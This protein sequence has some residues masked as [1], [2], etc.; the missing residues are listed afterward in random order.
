MPQRREIGRILN[1]SHFLKSSHSSQT[2]SR[3]HKTENH[4]PTLVTLEPPSAERPTCESAMRH[5]EK[6]RAAFWETKNL[7]LSHPTIIREFRPMPT[8]P[9]TMRH[10]EQA[11]KKEDRKDSQTVSFSQIVSRLPTREIATQPSWVRDAVSVTP[12]RYPPYLLI[13]SFLSASSVPSVVNPP[14]PSWE[15]ACPELHYGS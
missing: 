13:A 4:P 1:L 3:S 7:K 10:F 14:L 9:R 12:Q 6:N 15:R 2:V 11:V 8:T 5:F